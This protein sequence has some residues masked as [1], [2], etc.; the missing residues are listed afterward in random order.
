MDINTEAE[1]KL[2]RELRVV[3]LE[4][5]SERLLEDL[6]NIAE[7]TELTWHQR[8]KKVYRRMEEGDED[9]AAAFNDPRRS[10]YALQ[11]LW[12][13]SL[14]LLTDDK[15]ERFPEARLAWLE[16]NGVKQSREWDDRERPSA[17]S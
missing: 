11:L 8:Y 4:R 12:F 9:V 15:W 2:F 3:A 10:T 16:R 7:D 13:N 5:L 1:W 6:R 17:D 14:D